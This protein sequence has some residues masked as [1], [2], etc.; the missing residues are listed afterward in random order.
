[1]APLPDAF[2]DVEVAH[3]RRRAFGSVLA[4]LLAAG[5]AACSS[6]A[7]SPSVLPSGQW[8]GDH[9][10]LDVTASSTT[11]EFD[12]AHGS[13]DGPWS[14]RGDGSFDENGVYVREHGGPTVAG[15]PV[16]SQPARYSGR[17]DGSSLSFTAYL[18]DGSSVGPFVAVL[19]QAARV[20][21]CV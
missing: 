20:F 17:L 7:P 12:C 11:I 8:G 21:K 5:A 2:S 18:Q 16:D 10:R 1:M 6:H 14:L 19:G 15:E 4:L 9:V 3:E 13:V